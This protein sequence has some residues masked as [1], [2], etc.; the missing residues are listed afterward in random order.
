[1][2]APSGQYYVHDHSV[3]YWL[4]IVK[5]AR[6]KLAFLLGKSNA[7]FIYCSI[8]GFAMI[9][10]LY[11]TFE[12]ATDKTLAIES[13]K[14]RSQHSNSYDIVLNHEVYARYRK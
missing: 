13:L 2:A 3:S 8:R 11:I 1:L 7:H 12:T 10:T 5:S 9:Q 4:H 14:F 6:R